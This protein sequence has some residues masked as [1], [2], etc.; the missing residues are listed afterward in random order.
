MP[1]NPVRALS[2]MQHN[3]LVDGQE[4]D[5]KLEFGDEVF[6]A[7]EEDYGFIDEEITRVAKEF[8]EKEPL[9]EIVKNALGKKKKLNQDEADDVMFDV[10]QQ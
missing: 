2:F 5:L 3:V 7:E 8:S 1:S 10:Q 6:C 9:D 4:E